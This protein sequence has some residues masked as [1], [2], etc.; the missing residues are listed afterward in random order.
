MPSNL[1]G[2]IGV[3]PTQRT[4]TMLCS[5]NFAYVNCQYDVS[6]ELFGLHVNRVLIMKGWIRNVTKMWNVE[7]S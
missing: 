4:S 3:S 6:F 5:E 1:V 7:I 2:E